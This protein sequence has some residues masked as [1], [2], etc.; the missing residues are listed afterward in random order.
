MR[1]LNIAISDVEYS[2]FGIT[3]DELSFTDFV[4]MISIVSSL[5]GGIPCC[6]GSPE[7]CTVD[8]TFSQY[9]HTVIVTPKDYW[10]NHRPVVSL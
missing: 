5:Y 6:S 9:K 2:K 4:D 10:E 1:T 3:N 7:I 8:F